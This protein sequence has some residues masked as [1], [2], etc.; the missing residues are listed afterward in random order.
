MKSSSLWWLTKSGTRRSSGLFL[1]ELVG[2][3][4]THVPG[5]PV[6]LASSTTDPW[7]HSLIR[8]M[9]K[10]YN[11]HSEFSLREGISHSSAETQQQFCTLTS[12]T[13]LL[14]VMIGTYFPRRPD[15]ECKTDPKVNKQTLQMHRRTHLSQDIT[16]QSLYKSS[17]YKKWLEFDEISLDVLWSDQIQ[18]WYK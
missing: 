6:I 17:R 11:F 9:S 5:R 4:R 15:S 2:Y 14:F 13:K 3:R 10:N 18:V 7:C 12:T 1:F 8:A 16:F